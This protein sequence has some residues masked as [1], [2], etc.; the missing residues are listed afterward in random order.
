MNNADLTIS[1]AVVP[2]TATAGDTVSVT[3]TVSNEGTDVAEI[4]EEYYDSFYLSE[5]AVLDESDL[6]THILH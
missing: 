3:W 2:T 6:Y 1:D 5:D 4:H